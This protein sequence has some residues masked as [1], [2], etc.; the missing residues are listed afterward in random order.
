MELIAY[1][2]DL[3]IHLDRHLNTVI[4]FFGVW[5]YV[6]VF[7]I[8]FGETGLVVTP[9][10]PGDSLLFSL[11]AVAALGI[12][13][14]RLLII[15]LIIAAVAGDAVNYTLGKFIGPRIFHH[16]TSRFF[17]KEHLN[18]T[19]KFY[20]KHGGKTIFLARFIPI[21]RTFAPFV[22]GMGSMSYGRFAL[23][24]I[25]GGVSW[26]VLFIAAGYYFGNIP[27]VRHNFSLVI[28]A[29]VFISI[30]PGI[31]ELWRGRTAS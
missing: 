16:E 18:R 14:A 24:N 4:Q 5:T 22:A 10:L 20:E 9:I 28:M 27:L 19:H 25:S 12:L 23:Y 13:D 26:I 6:I 29:I 3:L 1:F 7:L 11:G 8:I 17:K 21:I 15:L 30:L 2:I 31:I